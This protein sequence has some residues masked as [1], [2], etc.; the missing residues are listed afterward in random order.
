M[1]LNYD[2]NQGL[3]INTFRK[4]GATSGDIADVV[5]AYQ[6]GDECVCCDLRGAA[7]A[8]CD[9]S[10]LQGSNCTQDAVE[11]VYNYIVKNS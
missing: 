10:Y 4:A 8:L 7:D 2:V 11:D 1:F 3:S 5:V 9:G 6:R